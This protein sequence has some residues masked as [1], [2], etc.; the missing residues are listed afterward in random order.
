MVHTNITRGTIRLSIRSR[1]G[2]SLVLRPQESKD[3]GA[4]DW[5]LSAA[6]QRVL[7]RYV[8]MR[9]LVIG[10]PRPTATVARTP[11][12]TTRRERVSG[13]SEEKDG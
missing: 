8:A 9:E 2:E 11:F 10:I 6:G 12:A 13:T 1:T 7:A 4:G 5:P 3:L